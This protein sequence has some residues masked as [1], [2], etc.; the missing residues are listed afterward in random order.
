MIYLSVLMIFGIPQLHK[1]ASGLTKTGGHAGTFA[2]VGKKTVS[3]HLEK[4]LFK[5]Q[6]INDIKTVM[7]QA[8][9][10]LDQLKNTQAAT[11][12]SIKD[13]LSPDLF[14]ATGS[15]P[16]MTIPTLPRFGKSLLPPS[17]QHATKV[18]AR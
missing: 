2:G 14:K 15:A 4:F 3:G 9:S 8:N 7:K 5:D 13:K 16:K 12:V 17:A 11:A 10:G 6:H 1:I 18:E